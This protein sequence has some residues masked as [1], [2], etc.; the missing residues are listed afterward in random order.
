MLL[1]VAFMRAQAQMPDSKDYS[2]VR[3]DEGA[4]VRGAWVCRLAV[5]RTG[6]SDRNAEI[7]VRIPR[8]SRLVW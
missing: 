3:Y 8:L 4:V 6:C 5:A 1:L 7:N 2:P